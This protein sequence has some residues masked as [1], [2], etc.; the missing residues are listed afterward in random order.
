MTSITELVVALNV[1]PVLSS[2]VTPCFNVAPF[3]AVTWS[4]TIVIV[5]PS[6]ATSK[7]SLIGAYLS[8]P[9]VASVSIGVSDVLTSVAVLEV[10]LPPGSGRLASS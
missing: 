10:S 2:N 6:C 5:S 7:A 8:L 1:W 9:I 4:F 3:V